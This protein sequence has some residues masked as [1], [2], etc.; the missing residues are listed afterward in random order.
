MGRSVSTPSNACVVVHAWLPHEEDEDLSRMD[1]E[2][3][4]ANLRADLHAKDKSFSECDRWNGREDH[5]ILANQRY[6]VG[7]SEYCGLVAVWAI[8]RDDYEEEDFEEPL[9]EEIAKVLRER[10]KASYM[11]HLTK[12]IEDGAGYFGETLTKVGT[13]SNGEAVFKRRAA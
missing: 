5:A 11:K 2:D 1:W 6:F 12:W 8:E 7:V 13:F 10:E 3:A 4:I 9:V